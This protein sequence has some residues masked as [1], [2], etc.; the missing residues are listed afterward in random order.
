MRARSVSLFRRLFPLPRVPARLRE[1]S[2]EALRDRY[3][4]LPK[5]PL[6]VR[7]ELLTPYVP[8]EPSGALHLDAILS[9][10]VLDSHP[11]PPIFPEDG[12]PAVVPLP[13]ELVWVSPEGRPLWAASDLR[14]QGEILRSREYWHKRAPADRMQLAKKRRLETRRG[15][16]KEYR[17][18][19]ATVNVP[20]LRA[21]CVGN[22]P[23]VAWLLRHVTHVGKK[24]SQGFGR[25]RWKVATL[26]QSP[27]EITEAALRARPVPAAYALERRGEISLRGG[28]RYARMGWTPPYWHAPWHD[29][30]I[31]EEP[32]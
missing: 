25:V 19:L 2:F 7:G 18:P 26:G 28:E 8:A 9:S 22:G 6:L 23:E 5:Q 10:A 13:L 3:E 16:Y 11:A 29:L 17:V 15:R 21:I 4:A 12:S 20:E 24:S 30:A 14:P 32:A 1:R 27:E 31:V